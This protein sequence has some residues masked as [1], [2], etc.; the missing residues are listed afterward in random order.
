MSAGER[1]G[2][3]R[4]G[5][6]PERTLHVSSAERSFNATRRQWIGLGVVA[7]A[8]GVADQAT[9]AAVRSTLSVDD[10]L[11]IV[12]PLTIRH[13]W[14]SGIAFG[15]F[16]R[17]VPVVVVLTAAALTWML[18]FF[19]RAGARHPVLVPALGLL[20]GG[21]LAN[22]LDRVRLGHVTDFIDLRYWPTF[23][24]ADSFITIGVVLLL[25]TIAFA[26]RRGRERMHIGGAGSGA[27]AP[28]A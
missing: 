7:L 26:D 24:L 23:N 22:L 21:S 17:A 9:K 10:S 11:H 18:L 1:E 5:S 3:M 13:V 14:N 8:A 27:N 6:T 25:L 20:A 4:V 28:N 15:L 16:S 2:G 12:G 19:A